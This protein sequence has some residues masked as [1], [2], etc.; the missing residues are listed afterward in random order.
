MSVNQCCRHNWA[1]KSFTET[2][3]TH[4][5]APEHQDVGTK[6]FYLIQ[7]NMVSVVSVVILFYNI[8]E[9]NDGND[10]IHF[11]QQ[12]SWKKSLF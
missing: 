9:I 4:L 5:S 1:N 11:L 2:S 8:K 10:L 3:H 12:Q 6:L 7:L